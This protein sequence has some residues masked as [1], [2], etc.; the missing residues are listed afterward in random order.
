MTDAEYLE[1]AYS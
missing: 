1:A